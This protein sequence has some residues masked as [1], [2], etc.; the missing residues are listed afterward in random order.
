VLLENL[1]GRMGVLAANKGLKLVTSVADDVPAVVMGDVKRL[2]QILTNLAGNAIK[3]T[4]RGEVCVRVF[5]SSAD[6]WGVSV[7]DTGMGM[8]EADLEHIFEP[9]YQAHIEDGMRRRGTGL[10]LSIVQ[11]LVDLMGGEIS[12]ESILGGGSVFTV[13]LPLEQAASIPDPR[14]TSHTQA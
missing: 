3:Y 12:V 11:Q 9:F 4:E 1:E 5:R 14:V 8:P 6:R 7:S 10:G 2:E 13:V